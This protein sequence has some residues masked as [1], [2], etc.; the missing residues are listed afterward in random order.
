MPKFSYAFS[1]FT[2][3]NP[4]VSIIDISEEVTDG[5]VEEGVLIIKDT[6]KASIKKISKEDEVIDITNFGVDVP[7]QDSS[8]DIKIR[9]IP[10]EDIINRFK[11]SRK[12][13]KDAK[14][15]A[16]IEEDPSLRRNLMERVSRPDE[17]VYLFNLILSGYNLGIILSYVE[18]DEYGNV[19]KMMVS[20]IEI[21]RLVELNV[22][23]D[24][25]N[26]KMKGWFI[27]KDRELI[28]DLNKGLAISD[29]KGFVLDGSIV[30][31]TNEEIYVDKDFVSEI[32]PIKLIE[33][34]KT[35]ELYIKSREDLPL[36]ITIARENRQRKLKKGDK[37]VRPEDV[38][39][40]INDDLFS[41]PTIDL[42]S[43]YNTSKDKNT[44]TKKT[45]S[46]ESYSYSLFGRNIFLTMDS[47]WFV[48][49]RSDYKKADAEFK[50]SKYFFND[51]KKPLNILK[52]FELGDIY[53]YQV[54]AAISGTKGRGITLS[55]FSNGGSSINKDV[56][57]VGSIETGWSIELY[58]DGVLTQYINDSDVTNN[59]YK[60]TNLPVSVGSNTY[61]LIFY[62]PQGQ[63]KEEER[64]FYIKPN[65]S[66]KGEFGFDF[67]LVQDDRYLFEMNEDKGNTDQKDLSAVLST[68]YGLNNRVILI[69][70][71]VFAT[72]PAKIS[73]SESN[74]DIDT[75]F[76][77]LGLNFGLGKSALEYIPIYANRSNKFIHTLSLNKSKD[78]FIPANL[79]FE[80]HHFD[81]VKTNDSRYFND[82][83][84]DYWKGRL[85]TT[86]KLSRVLKF[87][88]EVTYEEAQSIT[89]KKDGYHLNG[90]ISYNLFKR[91][92]FTLTGDKTRYYTGIENSDAGLLLNTRI[93]KLR[94]RGGA[95]YDIDPHERI[96]NFYIYSDYYATR[97]LRGLFKWKRSYSY[98]SS[99]EINVVQNQL[100]VYTVGMSYLKNN[101]GNFGLE[102]IW[103]TDYYTNVVLT[104]STGIGLNTETAPIIRGKRFGNS[105]MMNA[106]VFIDE[107]TNNVFDKD[108][109]SL[110][111]GAEFQKAS[112][113][114]TNKNGECMFESVAPYQLSKV[115][116]KEGS[117][118]DNIFLSSKEKYKYY[119]A[120]PGSVVNIDIPI[121]YIGDIEG[122][123][124]D[125]MVE[126]ITN[127]E[128]IL[129][130]EKNKVVKKMTTDSEGYFVFTEIPIGTYYIKLN[131]EQMQ[132]L[133]YKP[134]KVG[135]IKVEVTR[136]EPIITADDIIIENGYID[137][138]DE[139]LL[140]ISDP[141]VT[142]REIIINAETII[143]GLLSKKKIIL[144]SATILDGLIRREIIDSEVILDDLVREATI[145][146]DIIL[147]GLTREIIID[148]DTIIDGLNKE[149]IVESLNKKK[150]PVV[151]SVKV[152]KPISV[153]G[154]VIFILN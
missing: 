29:N 59:Q 3:H 150:E 74:K 83:V 78:K 153:P 13:R 60:F 39:Y 15:A 132:K 135:K 22:E 101:F 42:S 67:S 85:N 115:G 58:K 12:S 89:D 136:D 140:I 8:E 103:D 31:L 14:M 26:G 49:D 116:V 77:F 64:Y 142:E 131:K 68:N 65:M 45:E 149:E 151:L 50:A 72:D 99:S 4:D 87:P 107:N 98:S 86:L 57:I 32:L 6:T 105:G 10:E 133:N 54:P 28:I 147:E 117:F 1:R 80:Y 114:R 125:E 128:I 122:I 126:G 43:T 69:A 127:I 143:R 129:V 75:D 38:D 95:Y 47:E 110:V 21:M 30:E 100:N 112:D 130:D 111:E 56:D 144:D 19:T 94:L 118:G 108:I 102:Y 25:E 53:S 48:A 96:S 121:I 34:L 23:A 63:V 139:S 123:V 41:L 5:P 90:R 134:Q 35:S 154:P 82:N 79:I 152:P 109:D 52:R 137:F 138:K 46:N 97:N 61:K 11:K 120:R 18:L 55:S 2:D 17:E 16:A 37:R 36:E 92:Y 148:S 119:V 141:L 66:S 44:T 106:K 7:T 76:E 71:T 27:E 113:K 146:S 91:Y 33:N 124:V 104:Y 84:Y 81:D 145:D 40:L 20:L 73:G 70:G 9:D 24:I 88:F 93:D 51:N 62:G